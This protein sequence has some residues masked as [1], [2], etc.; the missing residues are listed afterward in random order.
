MAAAKPTTRSST[1]S[2]APGT[3]SVVSRSTACGPAYSSGIGSS[4]PGWMTSP[5][6]TIGNAM[7]GAAQALPGS[8]V[9]MAGGVWVSTSG[10]CT[11]GV[12]SASARI[13]TVGLAATVGVVTVAGAAGSV[14]VATDL[15]QTG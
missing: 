2:P 10:S 8:W 4:M 6:D 11:S 5:V 14:A 12:G 7:V 9:G 13:V 3:S 1:P 15:S